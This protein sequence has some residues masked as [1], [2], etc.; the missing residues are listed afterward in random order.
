MG[1]FKRKR[2]DDDETSDFV[3]PEQAV[4]D[5]TGEEAAGDGGEA[6]GDDDEQSYED[7]ESNPE[8]IAAEKAVNELPRPPLAGNSIQAGWGGITPTIVSFPE[9]EQQATDPEGE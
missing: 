4:G 7:A 8:L 1:L 2:H 6:P 9:Q 5:E 3:E